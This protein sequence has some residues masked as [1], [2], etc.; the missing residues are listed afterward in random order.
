MASAMG[1]WGKWGNKKGLPC[2]GRGKDASG[3]EMLLLSGF[4]L[5]LGAFFL[6][7]RPQKQLKKP[8]SKSVELSVRPGVLALF[9]PK[10]GASTAPMLL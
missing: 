4:L 9:V 8:E 5:E 10:I 7:K 2:H 3:N 6:K 1:K